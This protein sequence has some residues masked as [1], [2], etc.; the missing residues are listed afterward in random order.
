MDSNFT[1][2]IQLYNLGRYTDAINSFKNSLT[3]Q[4]NDFNSKFYLAL[5]YYNLERNEDFKVIAKQLLAEYPNEAETHYLYSFVNYDEGKI[6][7]AINSLNTAIEINPYEAQ[8]FGQKSYLLCVEKKFKE[9]L[10]TANQGLQI[11]AKDA[12]CLNARTKALTKLN[13]KEEAFETMQNTLNDNPE[14]VFTHSNA[15]WTNLELGKYSKA[16]NHF[17]EALKLDPNYDYART[18]MLNAIKAKNSIYKLFLKYSFW[19]QN[20]GAKSQWFFIIGIYLIYRTSAVTLSKLGFNSLVPILILAY[21]IFV[22]GS[23]LIPTISN[24]ILLTDTYG[25][26]LLTKKDKYGAISFLGLL[27]LL[28]ISILLYYT[29]QIDDLLILSITIACSIIPISK[30]LEHEGSFLKN[31]SFWYGVAIFTLGL[32]NFAFPISVMIP[33]VMFA[34]YTWGYNFFNK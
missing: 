18:G 17:K 29:L 15:G 26:H 14:D 6:V 9:A 3:H 2:G 12:L 13:R 30:G 20:K 28:I 24:A 5:S 11:D 7:N 23:W 32:I 25:K 33:I 1:R 19:I 4:P 10:L 27:S 22:L 8:Y 21:L 16:R 31:I 34:A